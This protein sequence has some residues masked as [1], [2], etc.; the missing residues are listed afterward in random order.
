MRTPA[1]NH[2]L[3]HVCSPRSFDDSRLLTDMAA[4]IAHGADHI[5]GMC[6]L[7]CWRLHLR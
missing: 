6:R 5:S 3:L 1:E 4:S 2:N 7:H